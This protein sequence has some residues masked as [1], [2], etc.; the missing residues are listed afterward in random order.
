MMPLDG[1]NLSQDRQRVILY[2]TQ[3]VSSSGRS[4]YGHAAQFWSR[5]R[6]ECAR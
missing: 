4:D 2:F 3:M 1:Y 6:V 5:K